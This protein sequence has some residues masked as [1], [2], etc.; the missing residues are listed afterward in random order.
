MSFWWC[1]SSCC[2]PI[3]Q[4]S[5]QGSNQVSECLQGKKGNAV[6][7]VKVR[8]CVVGGTALWYWGSREPQLLPGQVELRVCQPE[9]SGVISAGAARARASSLLLERTLWRLA[10]G[11]SRIYSYNYFD[12]W[13]LSTYY[14]ARPYIYIFFSYHTVPTKKLWYSF[15][16]ITKQVHRGNQP[17]SHS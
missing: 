12:Y 7:L 1:S 14:N 8:K 16:W 5:W 2:V 6:T 17:A 3:S 15:L 13:F 4:H 11:V 10:H 9:L